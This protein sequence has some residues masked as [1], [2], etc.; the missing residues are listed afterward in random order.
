MELKGVLAVAAAVTLVTGGCGGGGAKQSPEKAAYVAKADRI[1]K[2]TK[3][4]TAPLIAKLASAVSGGFSGAQAQELA[5]V[6]AQL[7]TMGQS[8]L[9]RL[10]KL[11][12]PS[13]DHAQIERFL[14][15]SRQIVDDLGR[16][17]SDLKAG[18][19]TGALALLQAG[20]SAAEQANS[21]AQ[22]YGFK[23]CVSVLPSG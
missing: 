6:T 4:Q 23:Q 9:T 21:A 3:A 10:Q 17:A 11:T 15:P 2:A 8:F 16:A 13:G 5:G 12:P 14:A 7:H 20:T 1:C 22:S 19:V 18:N